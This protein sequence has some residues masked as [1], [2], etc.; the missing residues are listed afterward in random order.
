MVTEPRRDCNSWGTTYHNVSRTS[1]DNNAV[2]RDYIVYSEDSSGIP[3]WAE[4]PHCPEY[5]LLKRLTQTDRDTWPDSGTISKSLGRRIWTEYKLRLFLWTVLEII[6]AT[7]FFY[8][9]VTQSK[10]AQRTPV[11]WSLWKHGGTFFFF[12][13]DRLVLVIYP[14]CTLLQQAE[15]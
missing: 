12:N 1:Y 5:S 3:N 13:P 7:F 15:V 8:F 4:S 2:A 6:M 11:L 9:A 10:L 14:L